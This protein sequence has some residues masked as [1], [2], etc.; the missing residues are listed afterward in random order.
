MHLLFKRWLTVEQG[1]YD[2]ARVAGQ[3]HRG[4]AQPDGATHRRIRSGCRSVVDISAQADDHASV[5]VKFD[6][7]ADSGLR[8]GGWN[9]DDFQVVAV[10]VDSSAGERGVAR[11]AA[12]PPGQL[13]AQSVPSADQPAAR[14]PGLH[15]GRAGRHL[16]CRRASGAD[17]LR[18]ERSRRA[19]IGSTWT[20]VDE[21]GRGVPAGTYYCR[22]SAAGE[23]N[24]V[25]IVRVD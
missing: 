24:V 13:L 2:D 25:K 17:P 6:I 19:C 14:D 23:S 22:A 21:A 9:I 15:R 11:R 5:Q 1:L 16:R 7:A 12:V 20:G 3:R 4:L 8:F 10:T 18:R